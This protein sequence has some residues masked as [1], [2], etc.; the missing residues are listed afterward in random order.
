MNN[1]HSN[2]NFASHPSLSFLLSQNWQNSSVSRKGT[3]CKKF[4]TASVDSGATTNFI[5][6]EHHCKTNQK[7]LTP[8]TA[9]TVANSAALMSV[10]KGTL[11]LPKSPNTTAR[12]FHELPRL[13]ENLAMAQQC[14]GA[15]CCQDS[16]E[17][18]HSWGGFED[19]HKHHC[20]F[21]S[22]C[23]EK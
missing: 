14:Q 5:T 13:Q 2:N 15:D 4:I 21:G 17:N 9:G 3:Q 11:N 23:G 1:D 16:D 22:Q 18:Q 12:E 8:F 20:Q 6:K 19:I 7:D 10:L